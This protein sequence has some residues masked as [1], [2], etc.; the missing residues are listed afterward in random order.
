MGCSG[1]RRRLVEKEVVNLMHIVILEIAIWEMKAA[2][3]I[4]KR[5]DEKENPG[6]VIQLINFTQ[7]KG[8]DYEVFSEVTNTIESQPVKAEVLTRLRRN[9][10]GVVIIYRLNDWTFT[11]VELVDEINML[12]SGGIRFISLQENFDTSTVTVKLYLKVLSSFFD[13]EESFIPGPVTKVT[14]RNNPAFYKKNYTVFGPVLN[15]TRSTGTG[16]S[17]KSEYDLIDL[18][19]ACELTGYSR[20]SLYQMTSRHQIPFIKR[21][22]GRKLFFSRRALQNWFMTGSD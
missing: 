16:N 12:V 9:E 20:H 7:M 3:Y 18:K 22:G 10:F 5:I 1:C 4:G 14:G 11:T 13:F 8:W 17:S 21:A 19:E 15:T 6:Q 2:I